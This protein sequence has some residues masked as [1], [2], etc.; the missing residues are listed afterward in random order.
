MT[1][2]LSAG[3]GEHG[4]NG[5]KIAQESWTRKD[6]NLGHVSIKQTQSTEGSES[7]GNKKL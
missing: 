6:S 2:R 5:T 3:R 1:R 7:R 4:V